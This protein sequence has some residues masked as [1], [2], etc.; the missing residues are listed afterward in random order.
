MT[1][2]TRKEKFEYYGDAAYSAGKV[3]HDGE[4]SSSI[5]YTQLS[6]PFEMSFNYIFT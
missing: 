5:D 3:P 1:N 2:I 4:I 6:D